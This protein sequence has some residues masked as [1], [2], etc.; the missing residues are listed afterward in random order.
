M[1][2]LDIQMFA[3]P[4]L[5]IETDLNTKK[6]ENGLDRIKDT[7]QKAGSTVKNIVKALG[8]SKI[9]SVAMNEINASI[10]GAISRFD[11]LNNFPKV[12][13]N[14][15]I[16]AEESDKAIKKMSKELEGLPTSLDEGARAVQRFASKNEDVERSTDLFLAL[17][18]AILAGGGS[19]VIQS[20]ALEQ[21]SQSYARG[22]PDMNEWRTAM[23]AMPAQLK[24]VAIA[25]GYV[26]ASE[27]GEELR[28]GTVSMDE[29]MDAIVRLNDEGINGLA[30]FKKQSKAATDGIATSIKNA[31]TQIVK[32]VTDIVS[33][34]DIK[35]EQLGFGKLND[36]I[37]N[38][39]VNAKKG[40][41]G[42][43]NLITGDTEKIITD[44]LI[45]VQK[46]GPGIIEKI[47]N[48]INSKMPDFI[49]SVGNITTEFVNTI[50][51]NLP[52]IINSGIDLIT[53][54]TTS[55]SE[56]IPKLMPQVVETLMNAY[57][58][59][60]NDE[61]IEKITKAGAD[62]VLNLIQ[63][64]L[65]S[66]PKLI[67]NTDFTLSAI[68]NVL[69][70]GRNLMI[71][72]GFS[73]MKALIKGIIDSIPEM[74]ESGFKIIK[75]FLDKITSLISTVISKGK[76]FIKN[77]IQGIKDG[78]LNYIKDVGAQL[79]NGLWQG[80]Q[81]KWNGLKKK[82]G[83]LGGAIVDKFKSV[84]GIKSPSRVFR[85][86]IGKYMA[87]GLGVGFEDE[88]GKVYRDMQRAID[89]EQ[90]KLVANVETGRVFNTIQNST[91]V[92]ISIDADVEM[93]STKVGRLVTP[94][95]SK[96]IKTG[97]GV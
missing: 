69:S 68:L 12:M 84:F 14:L 18:N 38:L 80:I 53:T 57:M 50:D 51:A 30:S 36:V 71:K 91:P 90:E 77:F 72:I 33:A 95:V 62:L 41:D 45:R 55:I 32:G 94:V 2:K 60:T 87:E 48:G 74:A 35:L 81:E 5:V 43:A 92:A 63:G 9:I 40:L 19:A 46:E 82:V 11:T 37:A 96:T 22:K 97:G 78:G 85:D 3:N 20:S 70:G 65:N 4:K 79:I 17:N 93:D 59:L 47:T 13:S 39:G 34:L 54:F 28:E 15:G 10:D 42:I 25:M 89:I 75:A 29:F 64:I 56:Q 67:E 58:T 6:F 76:E 26:D 88:L 73:L 21:L 61:N 24:Q 66:I 27:L 52:S 23:V 8:I 1:L 83:E 44:S 7:T 16:S 49:N 31:K 86:E